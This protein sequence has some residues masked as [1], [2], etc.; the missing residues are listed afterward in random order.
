RQRLLGDPGAGRLAALHDAGGVRQC[1]GT[2]LGRGF[3]RQ[4]AAGVAFY[5]EPRRADRR[6]RTG[7]GRSRTTEPPAPERV[8]FLDV[9]PQPA[10][11]F[12]AE[13]RPGA[14]LRELARPGWAVPALRSQPLPD[15]L[16]LFRR[17]PPPDGRAL[18]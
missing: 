12:R 13:F 14:W 15:G 9:F 5:S 11:L 6:G 17:Q 4:D 8:R 10:A 2:R 1:D 3:D 7:G 18:L 16:P